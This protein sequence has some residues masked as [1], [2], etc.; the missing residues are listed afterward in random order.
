MS[1][2]NDE[3][4]ALVMVIAIAYAAFVFIALALFALMCFLSFI[5]TLMAILAWEKPLHLGKIVVTP[6]EAQNFVYRGI[7]GAIIVPLFAVFADVIFKLGVNWDYLLQI[8]VAGY[9]F[10]S[11]GLEFLLAD[12]GEQSEPDA[13]KTIDVEP[14]EPRIVSPQEPQPEPFRFA[15]WNDEDEL[16]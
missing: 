16:R 12:D 6:E 2:R 4:S 11:I 8:T 15:S 13:V 3:T 14:V 5:C 9:V 7:C 10:G 1:Q